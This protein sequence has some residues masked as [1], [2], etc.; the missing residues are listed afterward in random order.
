M[1]RREN[2]CEVFG[3]VNPKTE[4]RDMRVY[5]PC[6]WVV[7]CAASGL[8]LV[9]ALLT[10]SF[11][12]IIGVA[13]VATA[14]ACT[15]YAV[16]RTNSRTGSLETQQL[17]RVAAI[18]IAGSII[19]AGLLEGLG[20]LALVVVVL[21]AASCPTAV[22][23]GLSRLSPPAPSREPEHRS[24]PR[25][26]E[27][28]RPPDPPAPDEPPPP[29]RPCRSLTDEELC[30]A[31]RVSFTLLQRADCVDRRAEL[32]S[33][34]QGYLDELERRDPVG[35]MHWLDAGA[36][37]ASNPIKFVKH[38]TDQRTNQDH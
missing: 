20:P 15:C 7:F 16:V 23:W 26:A 37:A 14:V 3:Y 4:R 19:F 6:W 27:R 25:R 17:L 10:L 2:I 29:E 38:A 31:W 1:G 36:R 24:R 12:T 11:G 21:L 34:R 8:G 33:V 18:S 5:Q 28:D 9:L 32:A 35:F 30:M 22:R 13:L